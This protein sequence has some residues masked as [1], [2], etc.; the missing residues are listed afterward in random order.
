MDHSVNWLPDAL[1]DVDAIA[2]YI[3]SDSASYASALVQRILECAAGLCR[4]P[5]RGRVVPEWND[6][7][8]REVFVGNYRIIYIVRTPDVIVLTVVHG[9]RLLP[10]SLRDR[11]S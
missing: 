4:S 8:V 9:A 5:L 2:S 6:D 7:S 1:D 10:D 11:I 3:A